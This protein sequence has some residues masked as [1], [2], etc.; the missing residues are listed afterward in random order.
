MTESRIANEYPFASDDGLYYF[1]L[2]NG[3]QGPFADYNDAHNE[4]NRLMMEAHGK[5]KASQEG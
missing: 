3:L 4:M 1:W 5:D 2:G